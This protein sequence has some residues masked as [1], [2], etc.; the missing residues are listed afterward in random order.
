[1]ERITEQDVE[2]CRQNGEINEEQ[3]QELLNLRDVVTARL[4]Q[5]KHQP[6]KM[7]LH[8]VGSRV[9]IRLYHLGFR[10]IGEALYSRCLG[11]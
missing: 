4:E 2:G 6:I 3:Y 5:L 9:A 7:W 11:G 8:D 10:Q 1:M